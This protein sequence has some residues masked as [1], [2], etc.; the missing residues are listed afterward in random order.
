MAFSEE[1]IRCREYIQSLMRRVGLDV[2]IDQAGNIIGR[3]EGRDRSLPPILF[4]SHLDSV[5][6]GGHYDGVIGVLAGIECARVLDENSLITLHPLEVVIFTDEEGG[7]FG[8]RA[9]IGEL[10]AEA[11]EVTS[12]SGLTISEG[13]KVL[14]GDPGNLAKAVRRKG[15]VKAYL[16]LHIEQ[17]GSLE[18]EEVDIGVVEGIVGIRHWDV[19]VEGSP[20]HAGTTP[21][22]KRQD[23]LLAA[24]HFIL[25]VNR[26]VTRQPGRQVGTVGRIR[27]DPGAP[28]VIPGR[29]ILSLELRDLSQEKIEALFERIKEEAEAIEKKTGTRFSFEPVDDA[30][31]PALMDEKLQKLIAEASTELGLSCLFM[32]SGAGHDAQNMARIAPSGMIFVPSAGGIS[33]SPREF[34]RLEDIVNGANVLLQTILK[35]DRH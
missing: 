26:E 34:S 28:N 5:P 16:E 22:D 8:S 18:A 1:D 24:A 25:A 11:L 7:A 35:L 32:P 14:G 17:G 6:N 20:N 15:E 3:R 27:A 4:G 29:V 19:T 2:R 21:M 13:M 23:A 31:V 30:S 33:H 9:M 10:T 12:L